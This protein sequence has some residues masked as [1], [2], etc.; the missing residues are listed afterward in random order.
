MD[1][2]AT[3]ARSA[4]LRRRSELRTAPRAWHSSKTG[5]AEKRGASASNSADEADYYSHEAETAAHLAEVHAA[6]ALAFENA[7]GTEADVDEGGLQA[8]RQ[9]RDASLGERVARVAA[10]DAKSRPAERPARDRAHS[11][12]SSSSSAHVYR[13]SFDSSANDNNEGAARA[14]MD[15]LAASSSK[16]NRETIDLDNEPQHRQ[17]SRHARPPANRRSDGSRDGDNDDESY[18][19]D[20][21]R[22]EDTEEEG[23]DS[24]DDA[25]T[26][27]E[28]SPEARGKGA[29]PGKS[30][31]SAAAVAAQ[32][33]GNHHHRQNQHA[34][35]S[36][37]GQQQVRRGAGGGG[38]DTD[39]E[40]EA[41]IDV[42]APNIYHD[43]DEP[44]EAFGK[45]G[46]QQ[47]GKAPAVNTG[48]KAY[49]DDISEEEYMF[50]ALGRRHPPALAASM[51]ASVIRRRSHEARA[52]DALRGG[53]GRASA[54]WLVINIFSVVVNSSIVA[55][56]ITAGLNP[57]VTVL[58]P[59]T[60]ANETI[61]TSFALLST[62]TS[63]IDA[64][65]STLASCACRRT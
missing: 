29:D 8:R 39:D 1:G 64:T 25:D 46:K 16:P 63:R 31:S 4:D 52:A 18:S 53:S 13:Y 27:E 17:Q 50:D 28:D 7:S 41:R 24:Y 57:W 33:G 58:S 38:D 55:L 35:S 2:G 45:V 56:S 22:G 60:I 10:A 14:Q 36:R 34:S 26:E 44:A 49:D 30:R 3:T 15:S 62:T 5:G 65:G 37:S 42:K 47:S 9:P 12:N 20:E 23:D 48:G 59:S 51:R 54:A 43:N 21:R 6:Y 40:D 19:E 11:K 61:K 32:G